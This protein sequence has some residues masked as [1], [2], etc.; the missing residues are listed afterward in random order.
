MT[1]PENEDRPVIPTGS[2]LL[3]IY[4]SGRRVL[5]RAAS[6]WAR[7]FRWACRWGTS[8]DGP[9]EKLLRIAIGRDGADEYI[10]GYA[11][12]RMM[13]LTVELPVPRA[14]LAGLPVRIEV[15]E[16]SV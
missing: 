4:A 3:L 1:H 11:T 6:F 13:A 14:R 12:A 16:A 8:D 15:Q 2:D 9:D 7:G 5:V 10:D